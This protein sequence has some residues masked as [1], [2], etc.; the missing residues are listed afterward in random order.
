MWIYI[1]NIKLKLLYLLNYYRLLTSYFQSIIP[2][3]F[4]M[5]KYGILH[6]WGTDVMRFNT[7]RGSKPSHLQVGAFKLL[8]IWSAC[9][10]VLS[11]LICSVCLI[12]ILSVTEIQLCK[13]N[14]E[15]PR[16]FRANQFGKPHPIQCMGKLL[17]M[18]SIVC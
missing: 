6:K 3:H 15:F 16:S 18:C 2:H 17:V 11:L 14:V 9:R 5:R 1:Y 8:Q 4:Y 7:L 12:F 13:V 10:E